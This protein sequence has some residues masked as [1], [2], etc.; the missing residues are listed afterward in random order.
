MFA[1]SRPADSARRHPARLSRLPP[2]LAACA[3]TLVRA[4]R[5]AGAAFRS[6]PLVCSV[7]ICA[8]IREICGLARRDRASGGSRAQVR[9]PAADRRRPGGSDGAHPPS[10]RRTGG[11]D[12]NSARHAA[13]AATRLQSERSPGARAGPTMADSRAC[14]VARPHARDADANGVDTGHP[15][16]ECARSFRCRECP[17]SN[18]Q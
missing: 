10:H 15:S 16:G 11:A 18:D 8:E 14:W 1:V 5:A 13:F 3:A 12:S 6:L 17:M 9:R 4:L 7:A 2:A